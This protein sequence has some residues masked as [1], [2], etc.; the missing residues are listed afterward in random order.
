MNKITILGEFPYDIEW[1]Q[2]C[3]IVPVGKLPNGNNEAVIDFNKSLNH[4]L[5][6]QELN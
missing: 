4:K 2:P 1:L 3:V 6:I 5:S